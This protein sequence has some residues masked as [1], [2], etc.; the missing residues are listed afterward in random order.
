MLIYEGADEMPSAKIFKL[1][2]YIFDVFSLKIN[3]LL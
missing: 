3:T 2:F 1:F